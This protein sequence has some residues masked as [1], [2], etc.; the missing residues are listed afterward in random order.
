[1]SSE[2]SSFVKSGSLGG[3]GGALVGI[4]LGAGGGGLLASL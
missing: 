3:I 2:L 1:M 4:E